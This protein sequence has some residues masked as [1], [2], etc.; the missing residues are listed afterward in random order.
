MVDANIITLI[1]REFV[2]GKRA[3]ATVLASA[4]ADLRSPIHRPT[5]L[6]WF[7]QE[8]S[9][10]LSLRQVCDNLGYSTEYIQ[11][12]IRRFIRD[13]HSVKKGEVKC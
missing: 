3:A 6:L 10:K 12:L 11:R 2:D 4:V 5:A 13:L 7:A 8:E 9:G 1:Q